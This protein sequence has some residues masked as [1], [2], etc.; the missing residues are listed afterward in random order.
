MT[1][2]SN[3]SVK[4]T[5]PKSAKPTMGV[6]RTALEAA[7]LGADCHDKV[8]VVTGAYSGIGV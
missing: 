2:N 7:E 1:D 3:E 5:A 4:A 6:F 8:F